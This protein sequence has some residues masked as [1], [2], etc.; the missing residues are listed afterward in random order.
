MHKG[1]IGEALTFLGLDKGVGGDNW[2]RMIETETTI[3]TNWFGAKEQQRKILPELFPSQAAKALV[4]MR[5]AQIHTGVCNER[6]FKFFYGSF[7]EPI[8]KANLNAIYIMRDTLYTN[9]YLYVCLKRMNSNQPF[10][11]LKMR[12]KSSFNVQ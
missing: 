11:L 2:H 4:Q 8:I 9:I 6:S 3:S 1:S 10:Q 7:I 5:S 12:Q